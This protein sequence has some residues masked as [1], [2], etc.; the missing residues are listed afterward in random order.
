MRGGKISCW[1]GRKTEGMVTPKVPKGLSGEVQGEAYCLL[2][3][4]K[5]SGIGRVR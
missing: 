3:I 1:G 5:S 2:D 4:C